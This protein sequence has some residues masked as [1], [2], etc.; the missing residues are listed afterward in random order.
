MEQVPP[1]RLNVATLQHTR[2]QEVVVRKL[3]QAPLAR[4]ARLEP[5]A[6]LDVAQARGRRGCLLRQGGLDVQ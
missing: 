5:V 6:V 4:Q 1:H 3:S 2:I